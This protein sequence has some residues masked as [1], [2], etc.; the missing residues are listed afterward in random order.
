[1]NAERGHRT[2]SQIEEA[3]GQVVFM[4]VDRADADAVR[5]VG[6]TVTE[7]YPVVHFLVNNAAILRKGFIGDGSWMANWEPETRIFRDWLLLTQVLHPLL[8]KEG[9]GIVNTSSEG[10]FMGR[11]GVVVYD[12]I[13][14]AVVS[15]TKSMA[16]EFVDEGIRVNAIAPGYIIT[17]MHFANRPDPE[18]R[19]RELE[20]SDYNGCIMGRR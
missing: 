17:E 8:K 10:V 12:A 18:A 6:R 13:K 19:K 16:R 14:G 2:V 15:V 9:G 11:S 7:K 20:E 4:E 5:A 3:G 1:M